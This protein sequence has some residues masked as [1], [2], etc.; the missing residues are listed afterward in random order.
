MLVTSRFGLGADTHPL[1]AH[2]RLFIGDLGNDVSDAVL[3]AS[4]ARYPS[5]S[6]ARVV[7]KKDGKSRGYGFV[8]FADPKD[9]L[10]AWKEMEGVCLLVVCSLTAMLTTPLASFLPS[11]LLLQESTSA[12]DQYGSNEPKTSK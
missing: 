4:F 11:L 10:K 9:F 5:F 7:R 1:T 8:A 6:K 2:K 12:H 3:Q